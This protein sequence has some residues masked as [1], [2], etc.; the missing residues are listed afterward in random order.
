MNDSHY[1]STNP[2]YVLEN[3]PFGVCLLGSDFTVKH[4]N[5][6]WLAIAS[7]TEEEVLGKRLS[8][9]FPQIKKNLPEILTEIAETEKPFHMHQFPLHI[10]KDG[11]SYTHIYNF[12]YYPVFNSQEE[13]E[14]FVCNAI[15]VPNVDGLQDQLAKSEERLRLATECN[16]IS[17]WDLNLETDEIHH[18]SSL[19]VIFGYDQNHPISKLDLRNH[20]IAEDKDLL[21]E[22][23]ANALQEGTYNFEGRIEDAKGQIK[24]INSRGKIFFD[25]NKKPLRMLGVMHDITERKNLEEE[26]EIRE[27][28]YKF[29][30]DAMPQFIWI[31]D[32]EGNLNY[33]NQA[34]FDFSGKNHDEI[35]DGGGWIQIVHPDD[36][37]KNIETWLNSVKNKTIF[38]FEHRFQNKNGDFKWMLSRAV[39]DFDIHGNVKHWVGTST[40][41]DEIKKQ[42]LQKNDFIKMANHELKTPVTT[43]KGYVQLLKKMR[44]NSDDQFLNTSLN[45]IENQVNKLNNLIGDLLDI[46]RME[47]GQLPLIKKTFSFI[48]LVTETIEDIKAS[49]DTHEIKF[50]L[51][52]ET[53]VEVFADKERITQVL[54]NLLTNA[55]KYSPTSKSVTVE[56]STNKNDAIVS[57]LDSGIGMDRTELAKIFDRFYRVSGED[58]E[59]FPGFGI[60]LFI[61]KDILTRHKGN[62]WVESEKNK[63]SKFYFSLPLKSN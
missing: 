57:V 37:P 61:V 39:P 10:E 21:D 8:S 13:L 1:V 51:N 36:R 28:R 60:G 14:Y 63:G 17:T 48:K 7:C 46:T 59:T 55:I 6:K 11:F 44:G 54:N 5:E 15:E 9:I 42:E 43:I 33:F 30:A 34:V 52:C 62:I 24:W 16:N 25:D 47:S 20:I 53:D 41:I 58:E 45:T 18:S 31:A 38:T 32:P 50:V 23:L 22:A 35:L 26:I 29:L 49:E 56:L 40:D 4:A 19:A 27:V 3:A 12:M 2:Q